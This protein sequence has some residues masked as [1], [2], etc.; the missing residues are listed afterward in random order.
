M[1]L[2][3]EVECLVARVGDARFAEVVSPVTRLFPA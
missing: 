2:G 3:E 1:E